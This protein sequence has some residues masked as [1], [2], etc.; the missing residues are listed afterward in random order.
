MEIPKY[1]RDRLVFVSNLKEVTAD[2]L[3]PMTLL[4]DAYL[5]SETYQTASAV[6]RAAMVRRKRNLLVSDNGNFT[7]MKQIAKKYQDQGQQL[8]DESKTE[9]EKYG[10]VSTQ[11]RD[12]RKRLMDEIATACRKEIQDL[13]IDEITAKQVA[14][15]PHY[16]IGM[17]DFTIPVMMLCNLMDPVFNPACHEVL[18]FQKRTLEVYQKQR[19]GKFG[20]VEDLKGIAKFMV[21]HAYDYASAY[22]AAINCKGYEKDGIAISYGAPMKSKQWITQ[23]ELKDCTEYFDEKLPESYFVAQAITLGVLNGHP[24]DIPYHILGLGSPIL[25]ALTGYQLRHSRAVSIDSTAPFKDAYAGTIYGRRNAFLKMD[26]YHVAA[27][28]LVNDKTYSSVSPFFRMFNEKY[29]ADWKHLRNHFNIKPS[30]DITELVKRLKAAPLMLEK[31]APFFAKARSGD[32]NMMNMLRIARSGHNFW[33]L[34]SICRNINKRKDDPEDLRSW[35]EL[36]IKRYTGIAHPKWS[37][38]VKRV[39]ELMES[40]RQI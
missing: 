18:S 15:R 20:N 31:H 10:S 36:Q 2:P 34:Q 32:D 9:L 1:K 24:T 38:T 22:Q 19:Q 40:H 6:E 23:L 21:I 37:K 16:M 30:T 12:A 14:I 25:V 17:E 26:M 13:N 27:W 28:T 11:I 5:L 3:N 8:L 39:Y 33:V 4:R 7:R 35:I 29:P